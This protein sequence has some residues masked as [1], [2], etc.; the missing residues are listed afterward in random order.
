MSL[1]FDAAFVTDQH[2]GHSTRTVV[3]A[4]GDATASVPAPERSQFEQVTELLTTLF[5]VWVRLRPSVYV[6]RQGSSVQ[7]CK[8]L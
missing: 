8:A 2:A 6:W 4:T 1:S 5:P 3:C 7:S